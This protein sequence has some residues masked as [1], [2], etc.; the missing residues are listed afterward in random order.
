MSVHQLFNQSTP[1][2]F[3]TWQ[4][5]LREAEDERAVVSLARDFVSRLDSAEFTRLPLECRPGKFMDANDI[6]GYA[7]TLVRQECGNESET[8]AL[9]HKLAAFFSSASIRLSEIMAH[10]NASSSDDSRQSA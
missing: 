6:T 10:T 3:T 4:D 8:A 5:K 7:F 1:L 2:A 9:V